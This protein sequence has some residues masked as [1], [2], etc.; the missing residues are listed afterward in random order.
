MDWLS[1]IPPVIAIAVVLWRKEVIV[2]LLLAIFSAELLQLAFAWHVP[3]SAAINTVERIVSVFESPDNARILIF[4]FVEDPKFAGGFRIDFT[5]AKDLGVNTFRLI[6]LSPAD[7]AVA[8]EPLQ[9]E[10]G[11]DTLVGPL[12]LV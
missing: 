2:A 10:V 5:T 3:G 4:S 8:L 6:Q 7:R 9:I 12:G 1:I 11:Q